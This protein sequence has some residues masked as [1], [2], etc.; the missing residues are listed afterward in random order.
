MAECCRRDLSQSEDHVKGTL[1]D[2]VMMVHN[3]L[4]GA[5]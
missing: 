4:A 1:A 5:N 2:F 3:F